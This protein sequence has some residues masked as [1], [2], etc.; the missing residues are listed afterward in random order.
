MKN[1]IYTSFEQNKT[2]FSALL[3]ACGDHG[4]QYKI[5]EDVNRKPLSYKN[6][7]LQSILLSIFVRNF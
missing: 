6:I 5:I 3:D 2:L 7:I 4:N 1:N